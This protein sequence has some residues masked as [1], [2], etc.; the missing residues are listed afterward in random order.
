MLPSEVLIDLRGRLER[1]A[2]SACAAALA[3]GPA[4]ELPGRGPGL[5]AFRAGMLWTTGFL[6][7]SPILWR[8]RGGNAMARFPVAGRGSWSISHGGLASSVREWHA[9]CVAHAVT[10]AGRTLGIRRLL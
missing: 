5:L 3:T 9:A 6:L 8:A 1:T 7:G 4:R 2:F 10:S